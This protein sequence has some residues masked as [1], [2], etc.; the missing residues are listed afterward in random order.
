V[1]EL[2]R[3]P[4]LTKKHRFHLLQ[5]YKANFEAELEQF[6]DITPVHGLATGDVTRD[7]EGHSRPTA[8][9]AVQAA[10]FAAKK[11]KLAIAE[12]GLV[13]LT[14]MWKKI[15][16]LND[17]GANVSLTDDVLN[18]QLKS[19][20]SASAIDKPDPEALATALALAEF[21]HR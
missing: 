5:V 17:R 12:K 6:N 19:L 8:R 20:Q 14:K 16:H 3:S 21:D 4:D 13:E 11:A 10:T 1:R 2:A 9:T 18:S 15:P 7:A